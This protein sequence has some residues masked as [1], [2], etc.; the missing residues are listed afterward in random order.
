MEDEWIYDGTGAFSETK[1]SLS[2][3]SMSG[4][5][6]L[7]KTSIDVQMLFLSS[8]KLNAGRLNR[9]ETEVNCH[10]ESS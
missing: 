9:R 2:F 6:T 7:T 1:I 10:G 8:V 5:A 3:Y 4:S